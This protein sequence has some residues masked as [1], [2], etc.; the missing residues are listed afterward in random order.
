MDL[1][2]IEGYEFVNDRTK[3]DLRY[4]LQ[5]KGIRGQVTF[6]PSILLPRLSFLLPLVISVLTVEYH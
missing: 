6:L 2:L 5:F 3:W 4:R 1:R